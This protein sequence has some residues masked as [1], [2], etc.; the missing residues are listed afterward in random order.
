MKYKYERSIANS[1]LYSNSTCGLPRKDYLNYFRFVFA[2]FNIFLN[3]NNKYICSRDPNDGDVPWPGLLGITFSSIWYWCADQVSRK[4]L[5]LICYTAFILMT[6]YSS[7]NL[8]RKKFY[9]RQGRLH[10]SRIFK[11]VTSISF[12]ISWNDLKNFVY[13]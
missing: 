6:G 10:I 13:R 1:S 9:P 11:I 5:L 7:K 12:D 3:W 8:I 2:S 4:N